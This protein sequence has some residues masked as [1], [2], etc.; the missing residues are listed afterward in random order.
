M[1]TRNI[2]TS[3]NRL[4]YLSFSLVAFGIIVRLAQYFSKRSLWHDEAGLALNI[5]NRSYLELLGTLDNNQSAPPL[6]LWIEKLFIQI[7]GINELSL[8]LFPLLAGIISIF[9]FYTFA[10]RFVYG[11]TVP[12]AIALFPS[13]K[14]TVYYAGEVKPYDVDLTVALLLFLILAPLCKQYLN[15]RKNI[16]LGVLGVIAIWLSYPSV[17]VLTGVELWGWF[18]T[19]PRKLKSVFFNRSIV[20]CFWSIGFTSLYFL[21]IKK[22]LDNPGLVESWATR[23]PDSFLDFV[24]LFDAFGRFFYR[25]LGFLGWSD[26]IAIFAFCCGCISLYYRDKSSLILLNMP[27][28]IALLAGYCYQ[29]PFRERLVHFLTPFAIAIVAEG[30]VFLIV[31]L[32]QNYQFIK[33]LG[34]IVL[35]TL[36][37]PPMV[38]SSQQVL[39]PQLFLFHHVRPVI[40][41]VR[42]KWHPGDRLFVFPSAHAQFTYY[43]SIDPFHPEDYIFSQ[44]NLPNQKNAAKLSS[45]VSETFQNEVSQ[46]QEKE[47]VWFLLSARSLIIQ[48]A[49]LM[50]LKQMGRQLDVYQ[51]PDALGCLY[52]LND[53]SPDLQ[54]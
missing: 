23:Y 2:G 19:P 25:P 5:L 28:T 41:Y 38:R 9:L 8:R 44:Y 6:F 48:N 37:I 46:L 26:G 20:Y 36:V 49:L 31:G 29:Y 14:Y 17:F 33:I 21:V 13:L 24:W 53:E 47:R 22:T 40:Q 15:V 45:L 43:N 1:E 52:N 7:F 10:R 30:I 34:V 54:N 18:N 39:N 16:I 50:E 12:L 42:E 51:Q 3:G 4:R 27:L 35:C 32:N 11:I